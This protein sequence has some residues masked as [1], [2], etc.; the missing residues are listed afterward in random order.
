MTAVVFDI[1]GV[2]IRW[3]PVLA[4]LPDL[5]TRA[6]VQDFFIRTDF[7]VRNLRGDHGESFADL[8]A[9]LPDP[10]DAALLA[11]YPARYALTVPEA[12]EGTWELMERLRGKGHA[13]HAI[14]NWSAETWPGGV[15]AHPRLGTAFGVTVV[16]GQERLLKPETAIF[17]LLCTR[18]GEQPRDCL[19]IDDTEKN[20]VGAKAAGWDAVHFTGP[21]ALEAALTE[22]G[23]L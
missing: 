20:V 7:Y 2:L 5:G 12:I 4:F 6:A 3:D 18:A 8:A 9:E 1:G 10:D 21:D 17:D 19:F 15:A 11:R 13:I 14:T 22:R 23:L 16:S